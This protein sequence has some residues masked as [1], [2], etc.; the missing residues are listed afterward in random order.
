MP[1]AAPNPRFTATPA[2]LAGEP[3]AIGAHTE[4]ILAALGFDPD[5][6]AELRTDGTV[7]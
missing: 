7:G 1:V 4:E 3:P 5:R 2:Q 6:I